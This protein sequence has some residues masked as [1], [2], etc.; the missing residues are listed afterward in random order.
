MN[1]A[2]LVI[3]DLEVFKIEPEFFADLMIMIFHK[4]LSPTAAKAIFKEMA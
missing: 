2:G 1:A 3:D 4:E